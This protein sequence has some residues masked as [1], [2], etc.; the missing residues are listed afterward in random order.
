M[1]TTLQQKAEAAREWFRIKVAEAQKKRDQEL[2][3]SLPDFTD[4]DIVA[5]RK[6]FEQ[7]KRVG[8][9]VWP[10]SIAPDA[11]VFFYFSTP[12]SEENPDGWIKFG[13]WA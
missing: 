8:H 10:S 9:Q 2:I 6:L 7:A 1:A 12:K 3:E 11:E 5:L 13:G 4:R